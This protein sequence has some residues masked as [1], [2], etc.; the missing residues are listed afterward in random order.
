MNTTLFMS[1]FNMIITNLFS[2][3]LWKMEK[4]RR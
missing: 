4:S 3:S 1:M 2:T